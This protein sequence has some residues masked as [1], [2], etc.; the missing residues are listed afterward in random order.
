MCV[1]EDEAAYGR[2]QAAPPGGWLA[3]CRALC[4]QLWL[5]LLSQGYLGIATRVSGGLV[6]KTCPRGKG[7]VLLPIYWVLLLGSLL[8]IYI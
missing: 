7:S 8:G 4:Q 2:K 3:H 5:R 6:M 1:F